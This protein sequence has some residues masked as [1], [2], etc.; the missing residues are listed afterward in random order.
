MHGL[1]PTI[2]PIDPTNHRSHPDH[3][4]V[5]GKK[6]ALLEFKKSKDAKHQPNQEYYIQ[7]FNEKSYASFVYPENEEEVL[8]ELEEL[9]TS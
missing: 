1:V 3:M 2:L 9:F 7:L 6:W 8:R 4:V 5:V